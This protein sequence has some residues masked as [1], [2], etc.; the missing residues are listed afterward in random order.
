MTD[1][2]SKLSVAAARARRH[3]I[4]DA[5]RR[6]AACFREREAVSFLTVALGAMQRRLAPRSLAL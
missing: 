1:P 3:T 2:T 6:S 5:L 4:G